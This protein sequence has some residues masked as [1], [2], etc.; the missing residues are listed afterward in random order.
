MCLHEDRTSPPERIFCVPNVTKKAA[1][2]HRIP[3]IGVFKMCLCKICPRKLGSTKRCFLEIGSCQVCTAEI[4]I[5]QARAHEMVEGHIQ[6][7]VRY[8]AA[9]GVDASGM[10]GQERKIK[11]PQVRNGPCLPVFIHD[12]N[13][14]KAGSFPNFLRASPFS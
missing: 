1:V 14:T 9:I 2:E 5:G 12:F 11:S 6:F 7:Q 3:Q 10:G 4:Q 13:G 8:T